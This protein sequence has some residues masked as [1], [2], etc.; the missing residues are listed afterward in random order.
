MF[1]EHTRKLFAFLEK[2]FADGAYGGA[3]PLK[4]QNGFEVL[5]RRWVV[6]RTIAWI[7]RFRRL[8]KDYEKLNRTA[9]TVI[10][11]ASIRII[12]RRLTRYCYSPPA[13]RTDSKGCD[14][15]FW[16]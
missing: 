7:N 15:R 5:P 13:F 3:K 1:D 8:A 6:E 4:G 11:M 9:L 2:V 10:R 14:V 12:M 16:L